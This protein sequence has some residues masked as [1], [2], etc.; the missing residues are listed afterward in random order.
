MKKIVAALLL[1]LALAGAAFA[2]AEEALEACRAPNGLLPDE[3]GGATYSAE[4]LLREMRLRLAR[5]QRDLFERLFSL[6]IRH[7]RS[8]L[9]LLY[10]RL[11][12][13][14]APVSFEN[15][16]ALDLQACRLLLEASARWN[17]PAYREHALKAARRIL[18]FNIYRGVLTEGTSWKERPSGIF[19]LYEPSRRVRLASIDVRALQLLKENSPEWEAVAQRC[20]GVLLAGGDLYERGRVYDAD[21]R[22]YSDAD[23]I[24]G[25]WIVTRL[26]DGGLAP[27][28][29]LDRLEAALSADPRA[30]C[31][32]E[33]ASP[34]ASILAGYALG[35][36]GRSVM[37]RAAFS[38]MESAFGADGGLL[39]APGRAPDIGENLLWLTVKELLESGA[40]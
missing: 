6:M 11:D 5:G 12:A 36:A 37:A 35:R 15:R 21:R 2:S 33:D 1:A 25:L 38:A 3:P 23:A 9:L 14:L 27:L 26:L 40:R 13:R 7:F 17:V 28:R 18:R 10:P 32:G 39:R 31:R 4:V 19:T 29:A 30:L 16:V 34:A 24:D 22:T 20:L 8:P